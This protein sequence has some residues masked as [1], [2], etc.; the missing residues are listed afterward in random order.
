MTDPTLLE[1]AAKEER[2][3]LTYDVR[4]I[5]KYAYARVEAGLHMPGV[6]EVKRNI[7]FSQI[8][9]DLLVMMEAGTPADFENRVWY[10]PMR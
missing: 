10:V 4:T 3:L 2:I 8:I 7:P 9:D 6:I 1:W 5:P